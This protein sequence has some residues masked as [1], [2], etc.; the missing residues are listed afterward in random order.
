MRPAFL[1]VGERDHPDLAVAD[2]A[3]A[4]RP[5]SGTPEDDFPALQVLHVR[6][7]E[8]KPTICTPEGTTHNLNMPRSSECRNEGRHSDA[9]G[10]DKE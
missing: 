1:N 7:A 10:P 6:R 9:G 5:A 3:A 8:M 2:N 4:M